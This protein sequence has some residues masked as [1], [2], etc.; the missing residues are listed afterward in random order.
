MKALK[1]VRFMILTLLLVVIGVLVYSSVTGRFTVAVVK[2]K[3]MLPTLRE[4]DIVFIA[5]VDPGEIKVGDVIVYKSPSNSIVVIHRVISIV[6]EDGDYYYV[7]KGDNNSGPDT[8]NFI[9]GKGI[10]YNRVIGKVIEVNR[11]IIKIPYI[12]EITL[13]LRRES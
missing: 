12:G 6:N 8:W 2:G 3:S 10:P 5:R 13:L 1:L 11:C 7:T 4:G 9:S